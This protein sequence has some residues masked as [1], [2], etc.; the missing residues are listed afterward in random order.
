VIGHRGASAAAPDNSRESL[1]AA[2]AA[3]GFTSNADQALL[4]W[5]GNGA[6]NNDNP[7]YEN[8]VEG[9]RDDQRMSKTLVDTL[10][11]LNDPRLPISA[12]PTQHYQDSA[13]GPVYAGQPT[14][15][16]ASA[17]AELGYYTSR[18]GQAVRQ[19]NTP[20]LLMTYAEYE[21]ILA[22]AAQRG[23]SVP[24]TAAQHYNA[25]IT[26]ALEQYGIPSADIAAYLA[27]PQ[28]VYNPT[29][30]LQQIALQKWISFFTMGLEAYT[31]YRRTGVPNLQPG[32]EAV[33]STV[34][35]RITYPEQEQ[36]FNDVNRK[37]AIARQ[38]ADDLLTP[39]WLLK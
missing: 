23:W 11:S 1:E 38:G 29:T 30:G 5:T 22:E 4:A 16:S 35:R 28:V 24:G 18:I 36:S 7:I 26:A 10:I 8:T 15:L 14:G 19:A 25:G 37:A 32:P 6:T 9:Q 39:T 34:P 17:A 33:T 21:F 13:K 20:S 31:E 12:E 27:Q 2:V 3:G